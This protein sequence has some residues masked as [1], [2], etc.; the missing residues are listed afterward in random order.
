MSEVKPN[1]TE[2]WHLSPQE[3]L[4]LHQLQAKQYWVNRAHELSRAATGAST[5][6]PEAA[7]LHAIP[8]AWSLVG[9]LKLYDWQRS[10]IEKWFAASSQGTVKVVTGAG[11]T[12]LALG[13]MERLQSQD[14][15]DLR[16]AIVV[17]TIVL[18]EQW[19]DEIATRSNLPVR[20]FGRLGGGHEDDFGSDRRILICVLNSAQAK[21]PT[22]VQDSG[23]GQRLLLVVDECHRAGSAVMQRVFRTRRQY[24]LGLSATPEREEITADD[25]SAVDD[26]PD[27]DVSGY[28]SS[29]L[30]QELGPIIYH[31]TLKEAFALGVLPPYEIH[32]YG[33]PLTPAETHQY[34]RLSRQIQGARE[35]LSG[36]ATSRNVSQGAAFHRWCRA[37]AQKEGDVARLA[38]QYIADT[39]RR[40]ALVYR[41]TARQEAV[42]QLLQ[43]EFA[44]NPDARAILFHESIREAMD[45]W[46]ALVDAGLPAVPE[47]SELSDAVRE[48]SVDL[49]RRGVA[50]V[51]VS[52]RSLIEGFNVPATDI[53]IVVA[54]S[55][56]VRQRIQ[57]IGRVLRKHRR[58]GG[59]EKSALIQVLYVRDTVD[60]LIYEKMRWEELTGA[61]RNRYYLWDPLAGT[62][63]VEQAEPPRRPLPTET[64]IE[65]DLT[66]GA[67]YP[68]AYEGAE[69]T[70]DTQGNVYPAGDDIRHAVNPQGIPEQIQAVKGSYGRFRVTPTKG[71]VL[72]IVPREGAW[73]T[74]YVTTLSEPFQFDGAELPGEAEADLA[75]LKPGDPFPGHVSEGAP[76]YGYRRKRGRP[77]ITQAVKR[78]EVWALT[79]SQAKSPE[80]GRAADQLLQAL[81]TAER[82]LGMHIPEF[83]LAD[84][85]HAVFLQ[86]GRWIYIGS[87]DDPLEFPAT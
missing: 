62:D 83:R 51:L 60:D 3:E 56:S 75:N 74:L 46:Q 45:L 42:I 80:R 8:E 43:Q 55:T 86:R 28:N 50:Q 84:G 4:R 53:G 22:L 41:A 13:L 15:P 40:K 66:P 85:R 77:V 72:V 37:M 25:E 21:L 33:L 48:A 54:S 68:G 17:P 20:A 6:S 81:D 19:Y 73:E 30:G 18:M 2:E 67:V 49:F 87:I 44:E 31:M 64:E 58:Q 9:D 32:H 27:V 12:I 26:A 14:Q 59:E 1:A 82:E 23:H 35:K 76:T 29:L 47:N 57:T 65:A 10:C 36:I 11:K 52:V 78:G 38:G 24:N 39:A 61:Q 71:Y 16:V 79:G 63:P 34:Q 70:A 69:Y 5:T 7:D